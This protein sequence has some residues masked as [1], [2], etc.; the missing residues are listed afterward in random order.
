MRETE[1][2]EWG[3]NNNFLC[4]RV[5]DMLILLLRYSST[6]T[7]TDSTRTVILQYAL[8]VP[9]I[10]MGKVETNMIAQL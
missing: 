7:S 6:G 8:F 10:P 3:D 4:Y 5:P 9:T 2:D 1:K